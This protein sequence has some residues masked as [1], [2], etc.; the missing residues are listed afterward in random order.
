MLGPAETRYSSGS[1]QLG[2][3]KTGR[4]QWGKNSYRSLLS[5]ISLWGQVERERSKFHLVP[6]FPK[7]R[8][9]EENRWNEVFLSSCSRSWK[10]AFATTKGISWRMHVST[11]VW[12]LGNRLGIWDTQG[13]AA[14][15]LSSCASF[16][17]SLSLGA[18]VREG[19]LSSQLLWSLVLKSP[20]Q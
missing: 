16:Q 7:F 9:A 15:S 5:W 13:Q 19:P 6:S 2:A 11:D 20:I 14:S 8:L 3:W 4:S 12:Q 10:L 18:P 17:G 1:L